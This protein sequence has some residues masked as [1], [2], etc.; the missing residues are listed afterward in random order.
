M[1]EAENAFKATLGSD[2]IL[3]G[4]WSSLASPLLAEIVAENKSF[5][6]ILFDTEHAP[7]DV[8]TLLGQLQAIRFSGV[9]AVVRP[10]Q[11][12]P[13]EIKRL[14]DI[15]FRSLLIP[16]VDSAQQA[17]DAVRATRYPPYGIRGASAYHRNNGYGRIENYFEFINDAIAVIAQI[18]TIEAVAHLEEIG[19]VEGVNALFVGPGDLAA[20]LGYLGQVRAPAVQDII[21]KIG[22]RARKCGFKLGIAA[23]TMD[24]VARYREWG[25]SVFAVSSDVLLFR[26]AVEGLA[27][28]FARFK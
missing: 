25:Y 2:E 17:K 24:D 21:K 26:R 15:G 3:L 10:V 6:W 4:F 5:Q 13:V 27:E 18:E 19:S 9:P 20:S 12:H 14:L 23:G 28:S 16:S 7:N 11:N 8:Q 22:E 1:L